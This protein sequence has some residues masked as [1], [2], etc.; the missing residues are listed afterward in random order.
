MTTTNGKANEDICP[1]CGQH[2]V[3]ERLDSF[4]DQGGCIPVI[5]RCPCCQWERTV[6]WAKPT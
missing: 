4:P 6:N 5:E 2:T 1:K 3:I